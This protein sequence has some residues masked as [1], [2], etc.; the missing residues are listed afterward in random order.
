[1]EA[2]GSGTRLPDQRR[3][4]ELIP[5]DFV[6]SSR[7]NNPVN[8]TRNRE[9][10][11]QCRKNSGDVLGRE[12]VMPVLQSSMALHELPETATWR[13]VNEVP[14]LRPAS[15]AGTRE[16]NAGTLHLIAVVKC[17]RGNK[18]LTG[19]LTDAL[20]LHGIEKANPD[21]QLSA[22]E[23]EQN[24][25]HPLTVCSACLLQSRVGVA[26]LVLR[27]TEL[28][29]R[30]V[31]DGKQ[32]ALLKV[33]RT[34]SPPAP[35]VTVEVVSEHIPKRSIRTVAG[36]VFHTRICRVEMERQAQRFEYPERKPIMTDSFFPGTIYRRATAKSGEA[37]PR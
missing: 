6:C 36:G 28:P 3:P 22:H 35:L 5:P 21:G 11:T 9:L 30:E 2:G 19:G 24:T 31:V 12:L 32:P 15:T 25:A 14:R 17:P 27:C 13:Q 4:V 8:Q 18:I 26:P 1:M 33:G 16:H 7:V 20:L 29:K 10:V 23:V 37:R 34:N